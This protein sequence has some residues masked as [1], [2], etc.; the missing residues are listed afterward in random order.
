MRSRYPKIHTCGTLP[1]REKM[2]QSPQLHRFA[3]Q[4][5]TGRLTLSVSESVFNLVHHRPAPCA[6][7]LRGLRRIAVGSGA[8]VIGVLLY[9]SVAG[10]RHIGIRGLYVNLSHFVSRHLQSH[11][12]SRDPFRKRGSLR[13]DSLVHI[14]RIHFPRN[15]HRRSASITTSHSLAHSCRFA[16]CTFGFPPGRG[17]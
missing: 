7:G 2:V 8:P 13:S 4:L 11:A 1:Y 6:D 3:S 16:L 15:W 12:L 14:G 17:S 5:L 9:V 10:V